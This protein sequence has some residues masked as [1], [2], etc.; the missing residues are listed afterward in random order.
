MGGFPGTLLASTGIPLAV[1][2]VKKITGRGAPRLGR[3]S[4][5]KQDGHGAPRLGMYQP[6]PPFTGTWEQMRGGGKKKE[7]R[8]KAC[9]WEPI[10]LPTTYLS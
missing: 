1:E 2:L 6:L 9:Y 7:L 8:E 4:N 5:G 10:H 3:S